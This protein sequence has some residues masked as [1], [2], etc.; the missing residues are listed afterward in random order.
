MIQHTKNQMADDRTK[1]VNTEQRQGKQEEEEISIISLPN[2]VANLGM[3]IQCHV[4]I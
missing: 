1:D 3:T 2:T 4:N